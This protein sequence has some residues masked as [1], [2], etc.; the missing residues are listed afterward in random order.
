MTSDDGVPAAIDLLV[1]D[2]LL[3]VERLGEVLQRGKN[4]GELKQIAQDAIWARLQVAGI[5][6][7][8]TSEDDLAEA[9]KRAILAEIV[10]GALETCVEY[11]HLVPYDGP[12]GEWTYHLPE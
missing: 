12:H 3:K 2:I 6:G 4:L 11:G 7:R 8:G 9:V 1:D 10:E 5:T